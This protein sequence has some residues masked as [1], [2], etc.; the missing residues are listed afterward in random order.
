[1]RCEIKG[2]G[3]QEGGEE[4]G[5]HQLIIMSRPFISASGLEERERENE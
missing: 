4:E 1:M 2:M 3:R 5:L